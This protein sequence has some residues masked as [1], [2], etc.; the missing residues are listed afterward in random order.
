MVGGRMRTFFLLLLAIV[1]CASACGGHWP[2]IT[3]AKATADTSQSG[4]SYYVS[5]TGHDKSAGTS[6]STAWRT[7]ARASA[8]VIR[9]GSRLLL[10]GGATFTG[11]LKFGPRD[12]GNPARPVLIGSFG[13]GRAT[14]TDSQGS[15][16]VIFDTA[17]VR[18]ANL[19]MVGTG[20]LRPESCGILLFSD[21]AGKPR[22]RNIAITNVNVAGF[23][24]GI[25][26]GAAHATGF[27]GVKVTN[28][29]LHGNL[30]AGLG[31]YGPAFNTG[32]PVYAHENVTISNVIAFGNRG[33]PANT[34]HNSGSGIVLGNV[35]GASILWST[36][37]DNGGKGGDRNE[38]P[39]GIWTYDATHVMIEHDLSYKNDSAIKVDGGGFG[40]DENTTKSTMQYNLSYDNHGPGFLFYARRKAPQTGN[41]VRFNIS[42]GDV[43]TNGAAGAITM[44]GPV[45][46][47]SVYQNTVVVSAPAGLIHSAVRLGRP[48]KAATLRN[49]LFVAK[50]AATDVV[51]TSALSRKQA[52]L[53]GNDYYTT[54]SSPPFAWG[55]STYDSLQTW[56]TATRQEFVAAKATGFAVNPKLIGPVLGLHIGSPASP[57]AGAGFMLRRSSRLVGAGLDLAR[58]FGIRPGQVDFSGHPMSLR[59]PNVG[60]Q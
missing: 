15:A 17:G 20:P 23:G 57:A 11:Q 52:L 38:G 13:K 53:Q 6:P 51:A 31:S 41:T 42:S 47:A 30:D 4:V 21:L 26:I 29:R 49:N 50:G 58:L 59:H 45:R 22:L 60:A 16:V 12:A 55:L 5:P 35:A 36:T 44:N 9:P 2:S 37:Y 43:R 33:D 14:I 1:L 24:T 46:R 39:E 32:S 48:L 18:I 8:A 3:P 56:R 40:F 19:N 7:L 34:S 27:N 28:A 25:S 54:A 10:K